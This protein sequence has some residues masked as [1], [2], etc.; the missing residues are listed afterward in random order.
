[1]LWPSVE[2]TGACAGLRDFD[3]LTATCNCCNM[4]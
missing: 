2:A 4:Q 3:L 1:M